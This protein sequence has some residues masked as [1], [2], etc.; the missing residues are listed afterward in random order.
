MHWRV[1]C[2]AVV[3]AIAVLSVNVP[4]PV[5]RDAREARAPVGPA[6]GGL[7]T[8][9]T[10][11]TFFPAQRFTWGNEGIFRVKGPLDGVFYARA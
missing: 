6:A 5:L 11:V 10:L 2:E 8:L 9:V 3:P 1:T 4:S 7:V